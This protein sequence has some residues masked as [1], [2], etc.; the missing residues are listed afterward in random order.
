ME[1]Q[2]V[3]QEGRYS[4]FMQKF[5]SLVEKIFNFLSIGSVFVMVFLTTADTA[6][7]YLFNSPI[8]S[9]YEVTEKYLMVLAVFFALGCSYHDGAHIRLTFLV[10]HLRSTKLKL[11]CNYIAQI[12]TILYSIFLFVASAKTNI[13]RINDILDVTRYNLPLG[14]AYM[15]TVL[16]LLFM[17]LWIFVDLWEVR[18]GKSCLFKEEKS[19]E[20]SAPV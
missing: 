1:F 18:K 17:S 19:E 11:A 12:V 6:G 4:K 10:D 3:G 14:P 7:R 13:G 9:S 15:V 2:E 8:P 5:L 16:G 20:E